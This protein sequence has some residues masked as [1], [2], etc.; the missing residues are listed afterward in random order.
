MG[1]CDG[2]PSLYAFVKA[3]A[4]VQA[5]F[6]MRPAAYLPGAIRRSTKK[7][8]LQKIL[9]TILSIR[10]H[11]RKP[12]TTAKS[13]QTHI[14]ARL[15]SLNDLNFDVIFDVT[16]ATPPSDAMDLLRDAAHLCRDVARAE[17]SLAEYQLVKISTRIQ[18]GI[19]IDR[20]YGTIWHPFTIGLDDRHLSRT[21]LHRIRRALWRL[22][23]YFEAFFEPYLPMR[24]ASVQED[25]EFVRDAARAQ[26]QSF[27]KAEDSFSAKRAFLKPQSSLFLHLTQWELEEM[28][29]A[30]YHLRYQSRHLWSRP[31]PHCLEDLLPDDLVRHTCEC[32]G[33]GTGEHDRGSWHYNFRYICQWF[34]HEI[35][36]FGENDYLASWDNP[37]ARLPSEG[38]AFFSF[39]KAQHDIYPG[40]N[41][42]N[43]WRGPYSE[44]LSWGYCMWSPARMRAWHLVSDEDQNEDAVV[45]WWSSIKWRKERQE[46]QAYEKAQCGCHCLRLRGD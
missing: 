5:L 17:V 37:L 10:Q 43:H 31:C 22:R 11:R 34:R 19:A 9:C 28:E 20:S 44:F 2:A 15:R 42:C 32:Q 8:Q 6:E 16:E 29:C 13:L 33:K 45:E 26:L 21:E 25:T 30:W 38:Y 40:C 39:T 14:D 3:H 4:Q 24:R 36:W 12:R 41:P 23:L 1:F 18:S 27:K 7:L 35:E 46:R